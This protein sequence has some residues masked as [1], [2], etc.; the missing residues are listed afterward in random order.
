MICYPRTR[1]G[2]AHAKVHPVHLYTRIRHNTRVTYTRSRAR[3]S[4]RSLR[5]CE[6]GSAGLLLSRIFEIVPCRAGRECTKPVPGTL[7]F[8]I[9]C[10]EI[11]L[12]NETIW[13]LRRRCL[14]P[15][16]CDYM[17]RESVREDTAAKQIPLGSIRIPGA[18]GSFAKCT[19]QNVT[20]RATVTGRKRDVDSRCP[21]KKSR[22]VISI[23]QFSRLAGTVAF[24]CCETGFPCNNVSL[25]ARKKHD[26]TVYM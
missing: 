22:G 19:R 8:S 25:H 14:V 20:M 23:C 6:T 17:H 5:E 3:A 10:R 16:A 2:I 26:W 7:E 15:P 11:A 13:S 9:L 4:Q 18:R 24:L 21:A 12:I 1:D